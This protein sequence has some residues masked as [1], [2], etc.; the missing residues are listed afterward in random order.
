MSELVSTSDKAFSGVRYSS[1]VM[2]SSC[3]A[4]RYLPSRLTA[5]VDDFRFSESTKNGHIDP[6]SMKA[7][8][9]APQ[10][11]QRVLYMS[12]LRHGAPASVLSDRVQDWI[13]GTGNY[14]MGTDRIR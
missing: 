11:G 3:T 12:V 6:T 5:E 9:V 13:G 7:V 1:S 4:K 10:I 2:P 14:K 8:H